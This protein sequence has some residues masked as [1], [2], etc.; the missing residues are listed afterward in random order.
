M[1]KFGQH[2]TEVV[3]LHG[4]GYLSRLAYE[5]GPLADSGIGWTGGRGKDTVLVD[6][7]YELIN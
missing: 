2:N 5:E 1:I 7:S 6:M 3:I 4:A